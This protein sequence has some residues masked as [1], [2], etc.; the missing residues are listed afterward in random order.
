MTTMHNQV[1]E[2]AT[3]WAKMKNEDQYVNFVRQWKKTHEKIIF[4]ILEHKNSRKEKGSNHHQAMLAKYADLARYLYNLRVSGKERLRNGEILKT[5][6][7][8]KIA[9]M[10]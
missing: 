3:M 10:A 1:D 7:K 8:K 4:M 2:V 5:F 9:E 6:E